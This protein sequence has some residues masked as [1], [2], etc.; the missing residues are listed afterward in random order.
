VALGLRTAANGTVAGIDETVVRALAKLEQLLPSR[1]R[2]GVN[3]LGAVTV[4]MRGGLTVDSTVLIALA[5]ACRDHQRL[6]FD[7]RAHDLTEGVRTVEPHRLVHSGAPGT[8]WH[9]ISTGTT[10]AP[11]GAGRTGSLRGYRP[12]PGSPHAGCP[13]PTSRHTPL[14][15]SRRVPTV[16]RRGTPCP[17]RPRRS[18]RGFRP[19]S[20][21]SSRPDTNVDSWRSA[22][23]RWTNWSSGSGR[24]VSISWR[25]SRPC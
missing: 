25:T 1:L 16:T 9:G 8:W 18:L 20:R 4:A 7:Y 19:R 24:V 3:A 2:H 11:T 6:R 14:G 13:K 21:R 17:R 12:A 5:T 22:R 10:G 15:A 23:T